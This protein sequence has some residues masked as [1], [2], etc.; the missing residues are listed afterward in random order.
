[1]TGYVCNVCEHQ[2]QERRA[3]TGDTSTRKQK[4]KKKRKKAR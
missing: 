2:W 1:M 3:R 4:L